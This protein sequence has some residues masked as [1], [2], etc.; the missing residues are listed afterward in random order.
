MSYRRNMSLTAILSVGLWVQ[1]TPGLA[2]N[3][4]GKTLNMLIASNAGGGTDRIGRLFGLYLE[5]YLP[6][7]PKIVYRN[8]GAG[9]GKIRGANHFVLKTKADGYS[10]LQTDSSVAQPH[11]VRRK[12]SKFN[13]AKFEA[14]GGFN[15]GGSVIFIRKGQIERLYKTGK[16]VIVG[17][18]SGSRSWQA[19]LVWGKEY[20]GWNVR[21]I[22]GYKG[23]REMMKALRQGEIDLMATASSKRI[24]RLLKDGVIDIVAQ[25]G[26][27]YGKQ[28]KPRGAYPK[29]PVFPQLLEKKGIS[30]LAWEGYN[31]WIGA[32]QVDK[33]LA[34]PPGT[35]KAHV[36]AYRAAFDK[37]VADKKFIKLLHKTFSKDAV[38]IKGA[39]VAE[40]VA[41]I[42]TVSNEAI[43]H[44][45]KL[46]KKFSLSSR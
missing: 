14:I 28:Y 33:W 17:A 46:R 25:E 42:Q 26:V 13:P 34:L 16:P 12:V 39:E 41:S 19:M 1:A 7:Q 43:A 40:I 44:A 10:L 27:G 8:F 6:G 5:K 32:S 35:P 45:A 38:I 18:T 37:V 29:A 15:A 11:I 4:E 20:L 30:K 21:W 24:D 31:S 22:P 3:Y 2:Q 9:G 36:T 23:T